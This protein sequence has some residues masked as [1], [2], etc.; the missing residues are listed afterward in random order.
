MALANPLPPQQEELEWYGLT[1]HEAKAKYDAELQRKKKMEIVPLKFQFRKDLI[2][3]L[4]EEKA[5]PPEPADP[6]A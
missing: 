1:V 2:A 3:R 4:Q 5:R 6:D